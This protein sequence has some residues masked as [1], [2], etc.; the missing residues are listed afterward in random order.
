MT[1]SR[2]PA[3]RYAVRTDGL[4]RCAPAKTRPST[5]AAGG[6]C[7]ASSSTTGANCSM[8]VAFTLT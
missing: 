8:N 2:K 7:P 1:A 5:L 6:Q 4:A 3:D